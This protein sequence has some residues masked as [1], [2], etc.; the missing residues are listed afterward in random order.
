VEPGQGTV[1]I[2]TGGGGAD[3]RSLKTSNDF[4]AY[5]ESAFHVTRVAVDG[6]TLQ[7]DMV[8]VDGA[9]RDS[10]TLEKGASL[11]SCPPGVDCDD[12]VACTVDS[13]SV[14]GCQHEVV[15]LGAVAAGIRAGLDLGA[16]AN[17]SLPRFV[18]VALDRAARVVERA[19]LVRNPRQADRLAT[20]TVARLAALARRTDASGTPGLAPQ[21]AAALAETITMAR[22]RGECVA[23]KR[24][25][26][27]DTYIEEGGTNHGGAA[28]LEVDS[29]PPRVTYLKFD[30][31]AVTGGV[32]RAVLELHAIR[33]SKDGGV[34]YRVP[35]SSWLEGGG[36][37]L[38]PEKGEV[39]TKVGPVARG[40]VVR[41]NVTDAFQGGP[42]LYTL[43][44][45]SSGAEDTAFASREHPIARWRPA[46]RIVRAGP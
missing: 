26:V 10:V 40:R 41:L 4:T 46:L 15:T 34:V 2:T 16:C 14:D 13:C 11:P 43:A 30:L 38:V 35:D 31:S 3:L 17:Q 20:R 33:R 7:A 36:E 6:E 18:A 32:R 42:G 5:A 45:A 19:A 29:S 22:S 39:V 1:Y 27:A 21:C 12:G 8:R 9:V 23:S 44:I 37:P 24:P 28:A 25:P